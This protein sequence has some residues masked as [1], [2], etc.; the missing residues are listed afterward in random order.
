M[1]FFPDAS[2]PEFLYCLKYLGFGFVCVCRPIGVWHRFLV[3]SKRSRGTLNQSNIEILARTRP[4]K[5]ARMV[6]LDISQEWKKC[7]QVWWPILGICALHLT[8]PSAHTHS[9]E[10]TPG[11]PWCL[12][13]VSHLSRGIEGGRER[14][15]FTPPPTIPAGPETRT[16]NLRVTS[17]TL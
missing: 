3:F 17:Q 13:Q 1:P 5:M 9:S 8:H 10:H 14:W 15:L 4:G 11:A 7:G 12:A 16:H 2:W 6:T